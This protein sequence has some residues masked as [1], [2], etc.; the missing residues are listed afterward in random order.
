MKILWFSNTGGSAYE[1][2]NVRGV[3]GGWVK[4]LEDSLKEKVMLHV[5]FYYPKYSE[6]F[7]FKGVHYYP[8]C[9]KGWKWE[10][11]KNLF[12]ESFIDK[13]DITIY[14]KLIDDIRPDLIHI[15]GTENPFGCLIGSV[16]I[17]VVVSIQGN[18]TVYYHKY[19]SGIDRSDLFRTYIS[20]SSVRDIP[21]I[22]SFRSTYNKFCRMRD[23][24]MRNLRQCRYVIGRTDWDYRITRVLA[25]ESNYFHGDE[26]LRDSFY[27]SE[28]QA[29]FKD[30]LII[31]T[32]NGNSPFKG[33]ETICQT[34]YLLISNGIDVEWR[35]A[36]VKENDL[37]VKVVK[38]KL[39]RKYPK[40]GLVLLGGLSEEH[41]A[42]K[43]SEADFYVMP[44]HIENSPN[45]LCEAMM[46]GMPC[47]ATYVG[48]TGS[49]LT[50]GEEGILIQDGDPWAMAGAIIELKNNREKAIEMG[51]KAREK[52]RQRH[53]KEAVASQYVDI[54]RSITNSH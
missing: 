40:R 23:R 47:I 45:N 52:A 42:Q 39:G 29:N 8:I 13:D 16:E 4:A 46:V 10:M 1:Y 51:K 43:L 31:H 9:R 2:L 11:F 48:G 19:F 35:V 32:T 12:N 25:P 38:T 6:K 5:A 22:K 26:L 36:G 41:L 28:W 37:I 49:L 30:K 17:P 24:E 18:I 44:S 33:F 15:H 50:D 3:G 14:K 34:L 53:S 27:L 21:F 54:Y 20:C 7:E